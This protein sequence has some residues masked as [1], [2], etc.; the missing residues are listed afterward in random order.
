MA[1]EAESSI[2]AIGVTD[3]EAGAGA[4]GPEDGVAS[5]V[6]ELSVVVAIFCI[7]YE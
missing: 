1:K 5:A 4:V 7:Q 2:F 3:P 6:L